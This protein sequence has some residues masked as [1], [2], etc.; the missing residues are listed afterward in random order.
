MR[1]PA[2]DGVRQVLETGSPAAAGSPDRGS[3]P[4]PVGRQQR[5]APADQHEVARHRARGGVEVPCDRR[6][7]A[8]VRPEQFQRD[9]GDEQ[10]LVAGRDDGRSPRVL[11]TT[12][13]S[14]STCRQDVSFN[15]SSNGTSSSRSASAFTSS[16]ITCGAR[17]TLM[18]GVRG[19]VRSTVGSTFAVGAGRSSVPAAHTATRARGTAGSNTIA[20]SAGSGFRRRRR[21]GAGRWSGRFRR[22]P[23]ARGTGRTGRGGRAP[24]R[25]GCRSGSTADPWP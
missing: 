2:S 12:P 25:P 1:T 22:D 5:V 24:S 3:S 17:R 13:P 18:S 16:A 11:V 15:W 9:G 6:D 4:V 21:R 20:T 8:V 10:L 23:A 19:T 7:E 14:I